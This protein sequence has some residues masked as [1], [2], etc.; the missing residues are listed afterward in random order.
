VITPA[1]LDHPNCRRRW[2]R[3]ILAYSTTKRENDVGLTLFPGDGNTSSP[4]VAWS[5]RGFAAFRRQLAQAE[6]FALSK[7]WGFGGDR[8]WSDV[9]TSLEP[10]LDRPMTAEAS[11]RPPS[12]PRSCPG[13]NRSSTSDRTKP[14][15]LAHTSMRPNS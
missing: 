7:M 6:G 5:Y 1:T 10:L 14:M 2:F 12:V 13:W 15:F 8:P 3:L 11:S 9:S 4:D